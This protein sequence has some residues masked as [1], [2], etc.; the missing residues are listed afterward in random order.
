M[1]NFFKKSVKI[2]S[3]K[4]FTPDL[5]KITKVRNTSYLLFFLVIILTS[6]C[7]ETYNAPELPNSSSEYVEAVKGTF[8]LLQP[9]TLTWTEHEFS[10]LASMKSQPY[11]LENKEG[12]KFEL[13]NSDSIKGKFQTKPLKWDELPSKPLNFDS[14]PKEDLKFRVKQL[15]K[16]KITKAGNLS[17]D[18]NSS[19]GVSKLDAEFGIDGKLF[20]VMK[21]PDNF[22]W[23][24]AST[25]IIKYDSDN[26][27]SYGTAQGLD[28]N[29]AFTIF[30]DSRGLYWVSDSNSV[31]AIDFE[32]N[33]IYELETSFRVGLGYHISEDKENRIWLSNMQVGFTII[34]FEEQSVSQFTTNEGLLA[35]FVVQASTDSTGKIWLSTASGVNILDFEESTNTSIGEDDLFGQTGVTTFLEN[36]NGEIWLTTQ[37]GINIISKAKDSLTYIDKDNIDE[38][39]GNTIR[40][41][42]DENGNFWVTTSVGLL[43]SLDLQ[44]RNFKSYIL[45][46]NQNRVIYNVTFDNNDQAWVGLVSG[47]MFVVDLKGNQPANITT[48]KGLG[49]ANVWATL[50]EKD[51][52]KWIGTY[53]GIDIID[54]ANSNIKHLGVADGLINDRN[55]QLYQ[56]KD[57][58]IWASGNN[59]GISVIDKKS[60]R[61]YQIPLS[62]LFSSNSINYITELEENNFMFGNSL[63]QIFNLN[64]N[65]NTLKSTI[66]KT[67]DNAFRI[68]EI[69]K[70]DN[71]NVFVSL[72]DGGIY[73]INLKTDQSQK[74]VGANI[75]DNNSYYST[76]Y[77][78][79]KLWVA[80]LQ[81]IQ[82]LDFT[83]NSSYTFTTAQGLPINDVYDLIENN[84]VIYAG[85]SKGL[86]IISEEA[87]ASSDI[88]KWNIRTIGREQGLAHLD[89]A[90]NSMSIDEYGRIWAG[91]DSQAL[92]VIE[93]SEN[94]ELMTETAITGLSLYDEN[95]EFNELNIRFFSKDNDTIWATDQL[96]Y[97]L[98]PDYQK[99][100]KKESSKI[101]YN[102]TTG[103]YDIPINLELPPDKNF[104]TFSYHA[105]QFRDQN[106]LL[107]TYFLEGVD[108]NWSQLTTQTHTENYRDLPPGDYTFKVA[109]KNIYSNWSEPANFSFTILPKW[110]QTWWAKLLLGI[111]LSIILWSVIRYR[112][113]WLK[114]E[115]K[116]LE[117][118]VSDRT[119][120]LRNKIEQLKSTQSQLIQSEKMASLGEL[121]AGIAH[122]IQNPLNFV[123]NFSEINRELI[124]ELK[125][126]KALPEA[127]RNKELEEEIL[128]DLYQN[129][130]KINQHGKRADA[131]VKG[132]L[133]HSRSNNGKMEP[134]NINAL[135]D[136]YLRLA[137]H[138][139]RAKDKTFNATMVTD[140]DDTIGKINVVPQDIGRVFLN[141]VNNA[142]YAVTERKEQC[143]AEPFDK[144]QDKP[145]EATLSLN[146][147][148][149]LRQA[150]GDK[151]EPTVTVSTKKINDEIIISVKDNG[152]G[153]PKNVV[154]KVFQPFFSTKPT[155][156]G[157]GLG[158]SMSYDII[159]AHG[160]ELKVE[161]KEGNGSLFIVRLPSKN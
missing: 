46:F 141:L 12:K 40:T 15:G 16:P 134:T 28:I 160:G 7:K 95:M 122:E 56:A 73:K 94:K 26:L 34:N 110:W 145:V 30:V 119:E 84:G 57:G 8:R 67:A 112:S 128:Y 113:Q 99:N 81:A 21:D 143:L 126:E 64:L 87:H 115:N 108:R 104:L 72:N 68:T 52:N 42:I 155:G 127:E 37:D 102:G 35:N 32:N 66:V 147:K 41:V 36:P 83:D 131:I 23:L 59:S 9:D 154:E 100:L 85:T 130:E 106:K 20:G 14:W 29:T 61:I 27:Y 70:I 142:F 152:N 159:K 58:K 4:Y 161:T 96:S 10:G 2:Q 62:K 116:I 43:Y 114:R 11:S 125:S 60:L 47:G 101:S 92:T 69:A 50:Q 157:T 135:A 138:G 137:Y 53:A 5:N 123:N 51:G 132:M 77:K 111:I 121:T 129:L 153:I 133:Q 98:A 65:N 139:L 103:P 25:A 107:Y 76:L 17:I 144:T 33:L 18:L 49:D 118:K 79:N 149:T 151:Y 156:K 109:S 146:T 1:I 45:D 158:L 54:L 13:Q 105:I 71:E 124:Q 63:G 88:L 117:Q 80:T 3:S 93:D 91:V 39:F 97:Q 82:L 19:V 78:N 140:F 48:Q 22:I 89:F 55:T 31:K 90:Q 24:S 6:A 75:L 136:E 38:R 148:K 86:A 150:Q 74:I 44:H 120:Q